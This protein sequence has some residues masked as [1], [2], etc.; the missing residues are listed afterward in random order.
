[1]SAKNG[2][3]EVV[4]AAQARRLLMAGAGLLRDPQRRAGPKTVERTIRELGF[5]Q[6]DSINVIE[7]A[8][9]LILFSRLHGYRHDMLTRLLERTRSVFE[10]WT[11]DAS[12][13]PTDWFPHWRHRFDRFDPNAH[14]WW[15]SKLGPDMERIVEDVLAHV[16]ETGAI[17]TREFEIDRDADQKSGTWWGWKPSKTALELLWR[18]GRIMIS[19]R[20]SFRKVYDLTERVLPDHHDLPA[21]SPEEYV[22]WACRTAMD[23]LGVANPSEVSKFWNAIDL[24]MARTWL[25]AAGLRGEVVAVL[26]ES[27]DGGKP[28]PAYAVADWRQRLRRAAPPPPI[29]RALAPFDPAIR[30][31]ARAKR[32]FGVDYRFEAFVPASKRQHGY[33]TMP[34]LEGEAIIA[35]FDPKLHR[36]RDELEIR[37]MHWEQGVRITKKRERGVDDALENLAEFVG[38]TSVSHAQ[39]E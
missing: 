23:R 25:K 11:H 15:R 34:I 4:T 35:R 29:T 5:V 38:A 39:S 10:H 24:A 2:Q 12:I 36:D 33:Y 18:D 27:I 13:I 16:G 32:L 28:R 26:V 3:P 19:R 37:A 14:P 7:R 1:M 17:S 22:D 20:E 30:D 8:H 6:V 21:P 31:R 9:H